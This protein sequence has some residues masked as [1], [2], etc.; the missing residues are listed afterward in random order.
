M[1]IKQLSI[2][3]LALLVLASTAIPTTAAIEVEGDAYAGI[4]SMYLWRGDNLSADN[5]VAQS[6]MDVSFNGVTLSYWS[7]LDLDTNQLNETDIVIDYS[8][9]LSELVS[10]SVG[11]ILYSVDG[12][13]TNELYLGLGLNTLLEPAVTVYYDYDALPGDLFVTAS[14]GHSLELAEGLGLSLG[15]LISYIDT[16]AFSNLHNY[17]LSAGLDYAISDQL[18][19]SP[20]IIFSA[21]LSGDSDD[22]AYGDGIDEE[23]MGGLTLAL[24]F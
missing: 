9:D 22:F 10:L 7:N 6:G 13:T 17:E 21:P 16:D 20:S 2:A 3:L 14:I 1:K 12:A 15:G 4:S 11:N 8:T 5:A 24:A 19:L 18:T 23:F